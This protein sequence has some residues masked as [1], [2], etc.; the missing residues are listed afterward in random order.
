MM[1]KETLSLALQE[2]SFTQRERTC[3]S[4]INVEWILV[5]LP[6][7]QWQDAVLE[8]SV[9]LMITK[10]KLKYSLCS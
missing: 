6:L 3:Y 8:F 5:C 4:S 9:N 10:M 1:S 2:H 7:S